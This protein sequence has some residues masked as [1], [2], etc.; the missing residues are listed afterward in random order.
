MC[1]SFLSHFVFIA[2][3]I[4]LGALPFLGKCSTLSHTPALYCC[5]PSSQM[6]EIVSSE[7]LCSMTWAT[8]QAL[9]SPLLLYISFSSSQTFPPL[10]QFSFFLI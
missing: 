4:E 9:H 8:S 6:L 2:L 5:L 3:R 1:F 7:P 10:L